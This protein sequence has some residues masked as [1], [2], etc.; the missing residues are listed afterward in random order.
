M[1]DTKRATLSCGLACQDP[2]AE[3]RWLEE[4]FGFE[5]TMVVE[6]PNGTIGH[7]ELRLGDGVIHVGTEWDERH[8]SPASMGGVNTQSIHIQLP[9]DLDAHCERARA[10]G[11]VIVRE[12]ADQIYGDRSYM[13][14]DPEGHVWTFGQTIKTLSLEEMSQAGGVA[15]RE[16]L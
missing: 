12:P 1:T 4:A 16:T 14:I 5:I 15:V 7:S 9:A 6:N 3:M 8:R 11:A 10:A 2:K 13:A